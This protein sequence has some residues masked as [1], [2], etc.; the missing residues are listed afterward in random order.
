MLRRMLVSIFG[1]I[2]LLL[3]AGP[4]SAAPRVPNGIPFSFGVPEG[5]LCPDFAVTVEGVAPAADGSQLLRT[6]L[7]DGTQ[8]LTGPVVLTITNTENGRSATFN[9]SGPTFFGSDGQ[10]NLRGTAIVLEF[11]HLKPPGPAILAVNGR[12]TIDADLNFDIDTFKGHV[13]NVCDQL[14]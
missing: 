2:A 13:S 14:S 6:T 11:G 9:V 12:G 5:E 8:I 7:P 1:A 10:L 4:A 3:L